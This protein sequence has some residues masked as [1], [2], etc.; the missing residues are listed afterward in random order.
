MWVNLFFD[1]ADVAATFHPRESNIGKIVRVRAQPH[2][3]VEIMC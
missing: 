3:F 1:E 2:V